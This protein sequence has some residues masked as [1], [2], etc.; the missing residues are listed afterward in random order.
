[1]E[2]TEKVERKKPDSAG[3]IEP[4]D[5]K[6]KKITL[7]AKRNCQFSLFGVWKWRI[8]IPEKFSAS[9]FK[10]SIMAA[11][12]SFHDFYF[13]WK[14]A[15]RKGPAGPRCMYSHYSYS[16]RV[17]PVVQDS[18]PAAKS[19]FK[20]VRPCNGRQLTLSVR[21]YICGTQGPSRAA[22]SRYVFSL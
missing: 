19:P 3:F 18:S 8:D 4:M 16:T 6:I 14:Y 21:F 17:L 13:G 11:R 9:K 5:T 1:M 2:R 12:D 10:F 20:A 15:G 22:V 7:Q